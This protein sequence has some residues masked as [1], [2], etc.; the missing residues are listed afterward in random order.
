MFW[1]GSIAPTIFWIGSLTVNF[2]TIPEEIRP[3]SCVN[4]H[5]SIYGPLT[6][7]NPDAKG[8]WWMA[9]LVIPAFYSIL[10]ILQSFFKHLDSLRFR[11]DRLDHA[12]RMKNFDKVVKNNK[13]LLSIF[14]ISVIVY[15]GAIITT[16]I[17]NL[18]TYK[19][20]IMLWTSSSLMTLGTILIIYSSL[21]F[22][23]MHTIYILRVFNDIGIIFAIL[24]WIGCIAHL[25][26][27]LQGIQNVPVSIFETLSMYSIFPL[28]ALFF[29]ANYTLIHY[30]KVYDKTQLKK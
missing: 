22:K 15:F 10:F 11:Q 18:T 28:V 29:N 16:S 6:N 9:I 7:F 8:I 30:R 21:L 2:I 19:Q 27:N 1:Y 26:I 5:W 13:L 4:G 3:D 25:I 24:S 12:W 20:S 17:T 14:F 23:R